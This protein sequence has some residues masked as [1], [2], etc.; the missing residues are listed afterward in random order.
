MQIGIGGI[1]KMGAAIAQ[2]LIEVGHTVTVWNRS[3][4]K[5][6]PVAAAGA[7]VAATPAD[8]ASSSEAVITI[9]TDAAA[10]DSV[11]TGP[12]GLLAPDV[13]GKL[14]IEMS[15]V[16]PQTEVVLA[17]K[18]RAKGAALVECPVGGSTGPARQGNLI[19]LMGAE[20]ADAARARPILEQLCRRLEHCGPIGA[21]SV[22]KLTI[23]MPLMIYWQALGEALAL[24][25]PL[26]LDPARIMDLLADTSGGPNVLKVRGPAVAQMLKGGEGGP[27]TF[28]VDSAVKD[29]RT[30]L[31]E[32]KSRGVELPVTEKTLACYEETKRNVSGAA[33]V[34]AVSAYWANRASGNPKQSEPTSAL[35]R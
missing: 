10:I 9:L 25:R 30:M 33:E 5:V 20:P 16:R 32:G 4:E 6:K 7:A 35:S 19:G 34:S 2:R 14:F 11:Y 1:G 23:N 27:V 18:V 3:A 8:L 12:S 28:D 22:M 31:A 26:G 21:G 29:L 13:R 17:G 24:C 15:T